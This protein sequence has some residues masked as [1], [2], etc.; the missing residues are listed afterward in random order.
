M[1]A[2]EAP[3]PVQST[4]NTFTAK[5]DCSSKFYSKSPTFSFPFPP[6]L[7]KWVKVLNILALSLDFILSLPRVAAY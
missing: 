5:T 1:C 7:Q 3:S 6:L 2:Q 4:T